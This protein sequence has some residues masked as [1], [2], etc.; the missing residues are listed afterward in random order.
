MN[1]DQKQ[2]CQNRRN[3]KL[4]PLPLINTDDTDQNIPVEEFYED[5]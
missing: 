5:C 1:V 2:N 3:G 4:K